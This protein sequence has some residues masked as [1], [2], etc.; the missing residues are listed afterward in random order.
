MKTLMYH[1][2][3]PPQENLPYFTYLP[4][5]RFAKQVKFLRREF[6]LADREEFLNW[7]ASPTQVPKPEGAVLTFDDGLV[8]HFRYAAPVLA[9]LGAWGIFYVPTGVLDGDT[10]LDVHRIHL[11]LGT[12]GGPRCMS[13]V[14]ELTEAQSFPDS[15]RREFQLDTYVR[16]A[17]NRDSVTTFKRM[18]NYFV[19]YE[20][21][22][23]ILDQM[24][25][26]GL[27]RE[28]WERRTTGFY[29]NSEMITCLHRGGHLIGSHSVSHRLMSKLSSDDQRE[30]IGESI[31][32]LASITGS[33]PITYCHP[34]G[35]FHSFTQETERL[36]NEAGIAFSFNVE[37][38]DI[39]ALDLVVRP[40][41]LP[42]F[43]CNQ[44]P[45]GEATVGQ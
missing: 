26:I 1:Y 16:Q 32:T 37:Q 38:R 14:R 24:I 27:S 30:E 12:L 20:V 7:V 13:L 40:H 2:I 17:S 33:K 9:D 18:M 6:G 41:A 28:E 11:L 25:S 35:G 44:F 29:M 8:D 22:S 42:R 3:R 45:H 19:D 10:V 23:E 31:L 36:L 34:Y 4:V 43:D 15:S 39:Q 21:R 5:E